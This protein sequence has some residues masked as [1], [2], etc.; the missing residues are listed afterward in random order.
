MTNPP[1]HTRGTPAQARRRLWRPR[2]IPT[3]VG[4]TRLRCGRSKPSSVHPPPWGTL[5]LAQHFLCFGRF[6]PT[7]VGNTW[8]KLVRCAD[9]P[10]HPHPCGE[11]WLSV[12]ISTTSGGSSPPLWGT[13]EHHPG[14]RVHV[15]FIPTPVGNTRRTF[16][17]SARSTVHPHPC[18]EHFSS[19]TGI[20]PR[21]GSSPPLWGTPEAA[22]AAVLVRRFIPTPVGNTTRRPPGLACCTVHPH[23]CGEH[24]IR[25]FMCSVATGSSPPL[26]GTHFPQPIDPPPFFQ[27]P[28][29]YQPFLTPDAA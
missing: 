19:H 17:S 23:P 15:R 9:Q 26:W 14:D 3:P 16:V 10:V 1:P 20:S 5:Q 11:H 18:G 29:F 27:G 21:A 13:R 22:H 12:L 8:S 28:L 6:I 2:L 25:A 4:N 7:P 24:S